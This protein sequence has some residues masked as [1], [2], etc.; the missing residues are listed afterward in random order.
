MYDRCS[1]V[2]ENL[3]VVAGLP[4]PCN[5]RALVKFLRAAQRAKENGSCRSILQRATSVMTDAE[6]RTRLARAGFGA[7]WMLYDTCGEN[8]V[9]NAG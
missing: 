8:L 5:R 7:A 4:R 9:T 6:G 3:E 2:P 1:S